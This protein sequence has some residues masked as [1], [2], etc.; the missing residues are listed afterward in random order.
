MSVAPSRAVL[1]KNPARRG[2]AHN[3]TNYATAAASFSWGAARGELDGLPGGKGV[4]IAHEAVDRHRRGAR[5]EAAALRFLGKDAGGG[6][7]RDVAD[8]LQRPEDL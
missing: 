2:A 7:V 5:A 4:N 3:L 1:T 6:S 8:C